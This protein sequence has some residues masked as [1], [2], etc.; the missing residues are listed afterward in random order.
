M[1][2][3]VQHQPAGWWQRNWKWFVPMLAAVALTLLAVAILALMS[4][5]FGMIK[6][7]DAYRQGLQRAQHSPAV[8]A[9]LGEPIRE[10]WLVMGNISVNGPSGEANL[11][12]PL[13][14]PK[15]EGDLYL[16]ATKS[17][18]Q[19]NYRTLLVRVDGARESIDLLENDAR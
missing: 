18:G 12:I 16:E 2:T 9:A 15:G 6:S 10:G 13:S 19:W 7:S 17:A 3:P 5:L 4:A 1:N 11:Q 14:G 8:V